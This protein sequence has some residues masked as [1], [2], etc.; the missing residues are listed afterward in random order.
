MAEP[1]FSRNGSSN[2][3]GKCSEEL[4]TLVP[5]DV[6]EDFI[7]W[8]NLQGQTASEALRDLVI[9]TMR[10]RMFMLRLMVQRSRGQGMAGIRQE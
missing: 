5:P 1:M 8:A 9:E 7:A 4:K 10:G 3:L 2:P 6:K